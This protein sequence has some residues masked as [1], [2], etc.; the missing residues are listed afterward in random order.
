MDL[1]LLAKIVKME[2]DIRAAQMEL[3]AA[4]M[5]VEKSAIL[6]VASAGRDPVKITKLNGTQSARNLR[7]R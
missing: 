4:G 5:M 7:H 1:I 2:A 6:R 3:V